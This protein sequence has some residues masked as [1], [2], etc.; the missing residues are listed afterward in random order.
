MAFPEIA[1][2]VLA[3]MVLAAAACVHGETG[4]TAD[5]VIVGQSA[6]LS[7][8][9]KELGLDM[10]MGV[11]TYFDQVNK[12]GGVHGRKLVLRS[13]DDGYEA[14]R[15]AANTKTLIQEGA[16]ALL[17]YVGTP[18]SEAAKP[19]FTEAKVPFVGA[20]TGAELL[21]APFNRYIFNVRASYY[22][23][24][25]AIVNLL[26]SLGFSRIA[27]FYQNDSYGKAGLAG[28][29]LAMAKRKMKIAATGT[30]ERNTTEV[31]AAVTEIAKIDPQ[32]VVMISAYKSCAAFI[33]AMKKANSNPQFMNVSFV[34]SKALATELGEAGRGVGISQVVPFPWS[35]SAPVVKE[36]QKH[37]VAHTGNDNFNFSS[38]EGYIA[39]KVFVEGLRRAGPKPTRQGFIAALETLRDFDLGGFNVTYTPLDH[40]GSKFVELTVIGRDGKF[41]R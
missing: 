18:T 19:I 24:T 39:A 36:Y 41:L 17:G 10:R 8:P 20:F 26:A 22:N 37:F 21:R 25:D 11:Q 34:G 5:T 4:V 15:A 28:V 30:V 13:L 14:T 29:E 31:A 3:G 2:G 12:S 35:L 27:V 33:T 6:A 23:E 32:A 7:G 1:R 16:F 38:L 9:A 40:N